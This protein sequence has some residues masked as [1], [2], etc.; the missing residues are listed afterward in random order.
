MTDVG[1]TKR[2]SLTPTQ[3]LKLFE[4]HKGICCLC[5]LKIEAGAAWIDEHMKALG[6]GGSNDLLN[7]RPVHVA[8]AQSKT[9]GKDG[10]NARI[11]KAKRQKMKHLGIER[12]KQ[13]IQSRGFP[14]SR[15]EPRIE[16]SMLPPRSIFTD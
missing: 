11:A 16:K 1:T 7:R 2:K 6:L 13:K 12:P 14:S 3:R 10:D 8:C 4:E 5:G 15:K 9:F